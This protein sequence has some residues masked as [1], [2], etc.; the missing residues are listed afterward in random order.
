MRGHITMRNLV[1]AVLSLTL[2]ASSAMAAGGAGPL[3]PGKPAGVKQAQAADTTALIVITAIVA[4]GLAIG[5]SQAS[6][7]NPAAGN[8]VNPTV[9]STGTVP[10][11]P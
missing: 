4:V 5:I 9:G 8:V 11:T 7:G 6:S 10:G 1:A 2:L 3:V